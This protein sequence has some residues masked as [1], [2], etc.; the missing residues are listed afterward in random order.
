MKIVCEECGSDQI[1]TLEWVD[2]NTGKSVQSGP[3]ELND[4]WCNKCKEHVYFMNEEDYLEKK[5][6]DD[7]EDYQSGLLYGVDNK[8]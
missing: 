6:Q 7:D 2:V 4:N 1:Q 5:K 8:Q 3:G